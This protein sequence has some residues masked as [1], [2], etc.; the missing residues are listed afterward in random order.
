MGCHMR[1]N[2]LEEE[3]FKDRGYPNPYIYKQSMSI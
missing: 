2:D 3:S 1:Y